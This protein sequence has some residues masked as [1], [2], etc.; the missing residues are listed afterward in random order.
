[1]VLL[2]GEAGEVDHVVIVE[3]ELWKVG[4]SNVGEIPLCVD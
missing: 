4:G 2:K 3:D 1:M